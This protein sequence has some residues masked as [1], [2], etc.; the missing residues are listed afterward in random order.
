VSNPIHQKWVVTRKE[1]R[2]WACNQPYPAGSELRRVVS[3]EDGQIMSSY[4]CSVCESFLNS[5]E[6]W[7]AEDILAQG[8]IWEYEGYAEW[9][10]AKLP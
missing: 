5:L 9:R 1:H 7:Y 4:W 2:C 6:P 10:A 8:D 3:A